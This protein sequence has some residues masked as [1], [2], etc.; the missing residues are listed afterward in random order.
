MGLRV[1]VVG[2]PGVGKTSVVNGFLQLAEEQKKKALSIT[3]GSVMLEIAR[4]EGFKG[5]RDMLRKLPLEVQKH[6]QKRAAEKL[7]EMSGEY[8]ALIIDTHAIIRAGK[9]LYL[10]GLPYNILSTLKPDSIVVV[11]AE[12]E[13]IARRR[14]SDTTRVRDSLFLDEIR[15]EVE[16]T[17]S[18]AFTIGILTG[19]SIG[20]VENHEGKLED[21]SQYMFD[22]IFGGVS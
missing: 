22:I 21:A 4:N 3:Y 14:M 11:V 7:V 2:I 16:I 19:A 6:L 1:I 18:T 10:V 13:E 15:E 20:I 5:D 12:P 9:G 8:D 17:I